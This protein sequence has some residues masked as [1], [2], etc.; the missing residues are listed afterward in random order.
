VNCP[1]G[2]RA[3]GKCRKCMRV[4]DKVTPKSKAIALEL[5]KHLRPAKTH[6]RARQLV[7]DL[8]QMLCLELE[9]FYENRAAERSLAL[10]SLLESALRP[11]PR[12]RAS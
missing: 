2:V 9:T 6:A 11:T 4:V 7:G 10:A 5:E 1:H 3:G 12:K 8:C